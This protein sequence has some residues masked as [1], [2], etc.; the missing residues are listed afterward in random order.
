MARGSD[1]MNDAGEII[2]GSYSL[3]GNLLRVY[4]ETAHCWGVNRRHSIRQRAGLLRRV[5]GLALS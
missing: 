3:S 5:S 4:D 1:K 2:E